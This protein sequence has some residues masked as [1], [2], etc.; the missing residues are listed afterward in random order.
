M[1]VK[2]CVHDYI[3]R[4]G[5]NA[6]LWN[7]CARCSSSYSWV[8][9]VNIYILLLHCY[10]MFLFYYISSRVVW[11]IIFASLTVLLRL[12]QLNGNVAFTFDD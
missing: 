8:I 7:Q 1:Q 12:N 9:I 6:Y 3:F 4:V 5:V 11:C 2:S 10:V